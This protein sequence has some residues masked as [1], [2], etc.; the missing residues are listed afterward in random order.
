MFIA[1][2]C[3]SLSGAKALVGA[4]MVSLKLFLPDSAAFSARLQ[5]AALQR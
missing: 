4:I 5:Q 3:N 1:Y 2:F